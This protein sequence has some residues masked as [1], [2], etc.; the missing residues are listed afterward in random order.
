MGGEQGMASNGDVRGM[1]RYR[2][3]IKQLGLVPIVTHG[4]LKQA[5]IVQGAHMQGG[6]EDCAF[7]QVLQQA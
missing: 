2:S 1:R 7:E 3:A 5:E 4:F 6:Q